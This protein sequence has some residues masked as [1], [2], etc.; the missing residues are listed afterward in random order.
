MAFKPIT[1]K[2]IA[3]ALHLSP[4]TV[5][6]ALHNSHEISIKTRNE[7]HAFAAK[8]NY[9]PNSIAQNLQKGRSKSIGVIVC[10]V[11][12]NFFSQVINGIES[13]A[14]NSDY[15]VIIT[16]SHDSSER[17]LLNIQ[18]LASG[19]VDGLL[20]SLS[21]GTKN[22]AYLNELHQNGLP[23]VLFDR[24][25]AEINTHSITAGNYQGAF[26]ATLHLAKQGYKRIAHLTGSPTLSN[27]AERL[28]GYKDALKQAGLPADENLVKYC[29]TGGMVTD[30]L[31]RA[32]NELLKPGIQ[33][34][35]IF[36]GADRI[37]TLT[38]NLL[39]KMDMDIPGHIGLAGF[40]NVVSAEIFNPPL[41][42]V[43]QP[44][45]EIGKLATE[46]LVQLIEDKKPVTQFDKHV[47]PA[48]LII[49]SSSLKPKL[50]IIQPVLT[51]LPG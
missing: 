46:L 17:E 32:L 1:I 5:S 29:E 38:L 30:E 27:T 34:D 21:A 33:A 11:D 8:H 16:Q 37:S 49:R 19:S 10:H 43:V 42:T 20:I 48:E 51:N 6:K 13:V 26:D 18:H 22:I 31:I 36:M 39:R 23:V 15:H 40:T 7:V 12:N 45:L 35:A 2:D 25:T 47:L 24:V 28:A 44:A 4:S 9:K 41:T 50:P 14:H 3:R